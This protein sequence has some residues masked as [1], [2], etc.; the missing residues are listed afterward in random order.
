[1]YVVKWKWLI[2]TFDE[3][4][5]ELSNPRDRRSAKDGFHRNARG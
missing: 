4:A 2:R 1:M 3:S 5:L